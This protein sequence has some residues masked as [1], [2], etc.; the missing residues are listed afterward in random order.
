MNRDQTA[1]QVQSA[2]NAAASKVPKVFFGTRVVEANS[3]EA[4]VW[5]TGQFA[6]NASSSSGNSPHRPYG[7]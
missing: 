5:T 4:L 6:S 3:G 2:V 1:S 7:T